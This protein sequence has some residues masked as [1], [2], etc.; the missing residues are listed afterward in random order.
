MDHREDTATLSR[1]FY[2]TDP[3]AAAEYAH[4]NI[5]DEMAHTKSLFGLRA[6]V[7]P[8]ADFISLHHDFFVLG[9]Y[10]YPED[11]LLRK[12]QAD[13]ATLRMLGH[14]S[15][16]YSDHDLYEITFDARLQSNRP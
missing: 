4:A 7:S 11:W 1:V 8:Y 9:N 16:S 13:G 12:L 14:T 5:F 2:L 6:N 15:G 3:A 10:N